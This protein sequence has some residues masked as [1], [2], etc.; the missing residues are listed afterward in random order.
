MLKLAI[1][2][3]S[4]ILNIATANPALA[5]G[6]SGY[7]SAH[8]ARPAATALIKAATGAG[9]AEA[10]GLETTEPAL[11]APTAEQPSGGSRV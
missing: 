1:A 10:K 11:T 6:S 3:I 8:H 9:A 7:R 5:C 2:G 4:T